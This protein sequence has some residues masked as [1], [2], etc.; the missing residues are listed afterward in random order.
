MRE[1]DGYAET[2]A[3][4]VAVYYAEDAGSVAEL[5]TQIYQEAEPKISSRRLG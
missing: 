3:P 4:A 1:L 5:M 2:L